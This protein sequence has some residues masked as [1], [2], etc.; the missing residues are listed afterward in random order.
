MSDP[1]L[2]ATIELRALDYSLAGLMAAQTELATQLRALGI[3]TDSMVDV[4]RNRVIVTVADDA[5]VYAGL[6]AAN[7]AL[8]GSVVIEEGPLF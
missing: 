8:P 5:A 7:V 2:L 3:R 1:K 4:K 6:K